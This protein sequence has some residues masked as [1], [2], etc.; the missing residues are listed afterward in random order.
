MKLTKQQL[1]QIIKE[2]L[3][4]VLKDERESKKPPGWDEQKEFVIT[5]DA[6]TG[7]V[8][9]EPRQTSDG[10]GDA[11]ENRKIHPD[12]EGL[13]VQVID[14]WPRPGGEETGDPLT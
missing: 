1:K 5:Y 6:V 8:H 10:R 14:R 9:A 2:E 3:S 11:W 4:K 7:D 13:L 12:V